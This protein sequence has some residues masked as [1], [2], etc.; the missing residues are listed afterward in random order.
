MNHCQFCHKNYCDDPIPILG[1]ATAT[2]CAECAAIVNAEVKLVM[3]DVVQRL[4]EH[5][6]EAQRRVLQ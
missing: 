1:F 5:N 6:I 3:R 4:I 2:G